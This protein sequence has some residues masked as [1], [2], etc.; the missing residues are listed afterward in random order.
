[1]MTKIALMGTG[2]LSLLLTVVLAFILV[3]GK[4][5]FHKVEAPEPVVIEKTIPPHEA[6]QNFSASKSKF[7]NDLIAALQTRQIELDARRDELDAR[8]QKILLQEKMLEEMNA[9][10]A[11][12]QGE[13]EAQQTRLQSDI[14]EA[15]KQSRD[16]LQRIAE[17][18]AKMNP[19]SAYEIL[20]EMDN[21]R[22]AIILSMLDDR[23]AAKIFD[24]AT[25]AGAK[26]AA[27][28]ARWAE[29]IQR[30]KEEDI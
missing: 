1:M 26:G 22:V 8:E 4:V 7:I 6:L 24:A 20:S 18:C 3:T 16:N 11:R 17:M 19:D 25:A 23:P 10:F 9:K 14:I 28:A 30:M 27:T 12:L 29:A 21:D 13:L 5:P 15:G 2:V